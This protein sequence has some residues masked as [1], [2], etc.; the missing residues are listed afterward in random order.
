MDAVDVIEEKRFGA[1]INVELFSELD[2]FISN[3]IPHRLAT[4]YHSE[5]DLMVEQAASITVQKVEWIFDTNNDG[6]VALNKWTGGRIRSLLL[7]AGQFEQ[8]NYDKVPFDEKCAHTLS[9]AEHKAIVN[10]F[11]DF[12]G[13]LV[14]I[15]DNHG[16]EWI[17][18]DSKL[19]MVLINM[20]TTGGLT[21]ETFNAVMNGRDDNTS[22]T[23]KRSSRQTRRDEFKLQLR[24][25]DLSDIKHFMYLI[26]NNIPVPLDFLLFRPYIEF[27][28]SCMLFMKTGTE[29][30]VTI[31]DKASL[32]YTNAAMS[33]TVYAN[34][35]FDLGTVVR[36]PDNL[37]FFP[38]T[39]V[40]NYRRGAGHS[41]FRPGDNL[42][43]E[44]KAMF[45]MAINPQM[46]PRTMWTCLTGNSSPELCEITAFD[47]GYHTN[48]QYQKL[49]NFPQPQYHLLQT[50]YYFNAE[51]QDVVICTA[52]GNMFIIPKRKRSTRWFPGSV[53]WVSGQPR[54]P[55]P[56]CEMLVPLMAVAFAGP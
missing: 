16:C 50:D 33:F 27:E 43:T 10:Q 46:H 30:A 20:L 3:P 35:R 7:M 2:A 40:S 8:Q 24:A 26:D 38:D 54:I 13:N 29:T 9:R 28:T 37:H 15:V 55:L 56:S 6:A 21:S 52:S 31:M 53:P 42:A 45:C 22:V 25:M 47:G 12:I 23:T 39:F 14:A 44:A 49:W 17:K 36:Q 19:Q 11:G 48:M 34:I 1:F 51:R 4:L 18:V 5:H 32:S 41:F